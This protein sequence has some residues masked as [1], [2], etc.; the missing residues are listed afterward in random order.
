MKKNQKLVIVILILICQSTFSQNWSPIGTGMGTTINSFVNTMAVDSINNLLYVGGNYTVAN[1][2]SA[3]YISKFDGVNFY[4]ML[5]GTNN[6]VIT[7]TMHNNEL[8]IGGSFQTANNILV[9]AISRWDGNNWNSLGSGM[10]GNIYSLYSYNNL[11]YAGGQF[12]TA[13]GNN[14]KKVA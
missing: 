1:G 5:Q 11:L 10:N 12:T 4:P 6:W 2:T 14:A 3:N 13:N 8:F 9:N 7:L